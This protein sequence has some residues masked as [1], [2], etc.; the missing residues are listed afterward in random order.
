MVNLGFNPFTKEIKSIDKDDLEILKTVCEGWY[1]EYKENFTDPKKIAKSVASFA[2]AHGGL[3]FIGIQA[4][5]KTNTATDF[6]GSNIELDFIHNS[7]RG[8]INP[9]PYYEIECVDI[10]KENPVVIIVVPSS[11]NPPHIHSDG[12]IYRRQDSSSDPLK[13]NNRSTIDELYKKNEQLQLEK[14]AFRSIDYG[15]CKGEDEKPF[16]FI[17]INTHPFRRAM[18]NNFNRK[19]MMDQIRNHFNEEF[20]LS[21]EGH[22]IVK[23]KMNFDTIHRNYESITLRNLNGSNLAYHGITLELDEFYC[24]KALI[25]LDYLTF[26]DYSKEFGEYI[27]KHKIES[28]DILKFLDV[29]FLVKITFGILYKYF[30]FLNIFNYDQSIEFTFET[31]NCY[32]TSLFGSSDYYKEYITKYGIPICLKPNQR[33]PQNPRPIPVQSISQDFSKHIALFTAELVSGFGI[34]MEDVFFI[35]NSDSE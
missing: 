12:R 9:F 25:P 33:Y 1:I 21:L 22:I 13:E 8:N 29:D 34:S 3:I 10:Q 35:I 19:N 5:A 15:F 26:S 20:E 17:Y 31:Q 23:G 16:L 28:M 18:I 4:N 7:I 30:S 32:R 14:D 11:D 24:F 2:N 6:L 27:E